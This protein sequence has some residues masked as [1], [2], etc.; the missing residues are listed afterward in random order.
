MTMIPQLSG[1]ATI[2]GPNVYVFDPGMSSECIQTIADAVYE[3]QEANEFGRERYALLFKPGI[4]DQQILVGFYTSVAGLGQHPGDV[5]INGSLGVNAK[6]HDGN[7]TCNFWRSIENM[8]IAPASGVAQYAVSQAAPMRRV[9]VKGDLQLFDFKANG[10]YGWASGGYLADSVVDGMVFPGSQQQWFSRNSEWGHWDS[11]RWNT[12]FLGCN[13]IPE[14]TFVETGYTYIDKTPILREK[15]YLYIDG[16]GQYKV[17]VPSLQSLTQGP[18]WSKG[19]TPGE[20]LTIDQ[21]YIAFPE[22]SS[23]A[24]INEALEQGQHVLFTPGI[25]EL[26]ETIRVTKS[27]TI[28]LGVGMPTLVPMHGQNTMAVA[29]VDGVKLAGLV[30]DAGPVHSDI[31]LEVGPEGSN[32]NHSANPCSLHDV[33]FRTGGESGGSNDSC[34]VINSHQ[35]I[36]EH[37]WIWRADH[38]KGVGWNSNVSRNG[39][40]VNGDDHT[41]YGLFNEHHME[42]QTLWNGNGGRMFFYQSE[43]PYDIP[44]QE[45]W[46]SH[47]GTQNGFASYKVADQVMSHEAWGLGVYSYFRDAAVK[48]HSAIEAPNVPG[49]N[50]H[51]MTTIWLNGTPGSEITHIIN[52]D[53]RRVFNSEQGEGTR[54][55]VSNFIGGSTL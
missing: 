24:A 46:T 47:N 22:S 13:V 41:V 15:P 48:L 12:L 53:G 10:E 20:S 35:V 28:L 26:N 19:Q 38:G 6:W 51:H 42:Y 3:K 25:Y 55:I 36:G 50:I 43:I 45:S 2:F 21:F 11:A 1:N 33:Y 23:A 40:V 34:L 18:T 37:F 27:D 29:D 7:A 4:Y 52:E 30:F 32:I 16:E 9:H 14:G 31:L 8:T 44:D 49:V 54:Q 5:A 39:V 17:F